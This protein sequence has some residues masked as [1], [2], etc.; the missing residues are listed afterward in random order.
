ML[1]CRDNLWTVSGAMKRSLWEAILRHADWYCSFNEYNWDLTLKQTLVANANLPLRYACANRDLAFHTGIFG[2]GMTFGKA[3]D[4]DVVAR[5]IL[6]AEARFYQQTDALSAVPSFKVGS[7]HT[8][9]EGYQGY[10]P[11]Y[12]EHC[13]QLLLPLR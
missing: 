5:K 2:K 9:H 10:G 6:D 8:K 1:Q 7:L 12:Q 3:E 13:R 4:D 11:R